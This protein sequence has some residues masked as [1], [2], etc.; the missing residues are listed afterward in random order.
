MPDPKYVPVEQMSRAEIM[1]ALAG[2]D[3]ER[4]S[5]ALYSATY[6]DPEW[7]WVQDECL[8]FLKHSDV[9][10]RWAD[11][12]CLGDLAMFHK[13][14]DLP[15]VLPEMFEAAHEDAIRDAAEFSISLIKQKCRVQ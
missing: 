3:P 7:R 10:V 14:L 5:G 11:A 13:V 4:I 8:K 2:D 15:R 9:R 1:R 12:T 6:Y